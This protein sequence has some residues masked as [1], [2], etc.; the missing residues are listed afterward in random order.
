MPFAL[1]P[2]LRGDSVHF[3]SADQL[4]PADQDLVARS[5]SAITHDARFESLD[6]SPGQWTYRQIECS[7]LPN[8]L[9]L[10]YSRDNG[11]GNVSRFSVSIPRQVEGKLRLIPIE[12]RGYSLFIPAHANELTIATFNRI[13]A[14]EHPASAPDWLATGLCYAALAGAQ[15]QLAPK[16]SSVSGDSVLVTYQP[17]L[18]IPNEGGAVVHITDVSTNPKLAEWTLIFNASGSLQKA[19]RDTVFLV[20]GK[21]ISPSSA[22]KVTRQIPTAPQASLHPIPANPQSNTRTTRSN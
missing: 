15:V 11:P 17:T 4:A 1:A 16:Q 20:A 14:E 19:S 13:R 9:F 21:Q 8:H 2:A 22:I 12:R 5:Q 3:R 18:Q 10:L 7:A 6:F